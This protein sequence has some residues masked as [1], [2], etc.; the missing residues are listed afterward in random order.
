M[1]SKKFKGN[2][3][4]PCIFKMLMENWYKLVERSKKIQKN[5]EKKKQ[6]VLEIKLILRTKSCWILN[7]L[8]TRIEI[9]A[10]Q[11]IKII[12]HNIIFLNL[13]GIEPTFL[14]L[15]EAYFTN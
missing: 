9:I 10:P 5:K 8:P 15:W 11:R 4:N 14:P 13:V 3:V 1:D 7:K 12:K 2:V 6:Q